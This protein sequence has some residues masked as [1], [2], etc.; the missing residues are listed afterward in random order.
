MHIITLTEGIPF[1]LKPFW[2]GG[3]QPKKPRIGNDYVRCYM[4]PGVCVDLSG[5]VESP[6][7]CLW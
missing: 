7:L 6:E 5:G 4:Q 3:K 2:G 1:V